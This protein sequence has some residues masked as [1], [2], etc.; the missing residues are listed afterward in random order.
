MATVVSS[1]STARERLARTE[2]V[3]GRHLQRSG[4][5]GEWEVSALRRGV[6]KVVHSAE[7]A[8]LSTKAVREEIW[9]S[10]GLRERRRFTERR[11]ATAAVAVVLKGMA[12]TGRAGEVKARLQ[13]GCTEGEVMERRRPSRGRR[14]CLR[15]SFA[16]APLSS[17]PAFQAHQKGVPISLDF[18]RLRLDAST[19]SPRRRPQTCTSCVQRV[20]WGQSV[21]R[22]AGCLENYHR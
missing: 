5:L 19:E 6:G 15:F 21:E 22:S 8:T 9:R 16:S 20:R 1:G 7:R 10:A 2:A 14:S 13:P 17:R 4:A 11:G 18:F 3:V 12:V